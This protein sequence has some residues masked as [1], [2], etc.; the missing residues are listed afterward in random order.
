MA[1]PA[2]LVYM[3]KDIMWSSPISI[4]WTTKLATI[5]RQKQEKQQQIKPFLPT[6]FNQPIVIGFFYLTLT[7]NDETWKDN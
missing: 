5:N 4:Y 7:I 1:L 2:E 6:M 3:K